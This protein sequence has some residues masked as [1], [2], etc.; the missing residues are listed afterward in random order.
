[1]S[2]FDSCEVI[3][4]DSDTKGKE[5]ESK[6]RLSLLFDM[7]SPTNGSAAA[8]ATVIATVELALSFIIDSVGTGLVSA[9]NP[10]A[11]IFRM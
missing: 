6:V 7:I 3:G 5:S 4:N 2:D 8:T 9:T 1:M 11:T 10:N